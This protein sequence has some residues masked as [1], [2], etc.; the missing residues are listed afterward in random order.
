MPYLVVEPSKYKTVWLFAMFDL[1]VKTK[2]QRKRYA[3][4]R[5]LLLESGFSQMQYSVYARPFVSQEA[6]DACR[7]RLLGKLPPEGQVRLLVVTDRQFAKM[8]SF[9]GKNATPIERPSPQLLLF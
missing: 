4:F 3:Q 1:P 9:S 8:Q 2:M 6:S 5:S 7:D